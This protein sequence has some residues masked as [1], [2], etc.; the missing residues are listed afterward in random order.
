[1]ELPLSRSIYIKNNSEKSLLYEVFMFA[2]L[3]L[4]F[5]AKEYLEMM[6]WNNPVIT[7]SFVLNNF[8]SNHKNGI[9]INNRTRKYFNFS[10][11]SQAVERSGNLISDASLTVC[12]NEAIDDIF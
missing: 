6:D 5:R 4:I 1:M 8:S 7:A 10:C 9:F 3:V 2:V 12:R 11:H